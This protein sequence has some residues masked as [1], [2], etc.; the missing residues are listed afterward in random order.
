MQQDSSGLQLDNQLCFMIYSTN[1]AFHQIYRKVLAS[2]GLT[3]PQY[4]VMLVL[5]EKDQLTVSEIGARLFLESSTL[6]PLLKKLESHQLIL[7]Q[8]SSQDERQV[9]ITLTDL[10]INLQKKALEVPEKV[11]STTSCDLDQLLA[12]KDQ[13]QI[14]RNNLLMHNK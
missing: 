12:L 7:R 10:G 1:L 8:R 13:L 3:Y 4:L 6:T 11:I 14:L 5:W 9:I 2:L